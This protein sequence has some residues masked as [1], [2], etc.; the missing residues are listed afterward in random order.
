MN[1]RE[2]TDELIRQL[3]LALS[4]LSNNPEMTE[5]DLELWGKVSSHPSIK[6]RLDAA[7]RSHRSHRSISPSS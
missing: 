7:F 5:A 3:W 4:D 6:K 1:N 2:K